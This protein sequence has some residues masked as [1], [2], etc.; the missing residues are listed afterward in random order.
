ML[1][2]LIYI[3]KNTPLEELPHKYPLLV[4]GFLLSIL[5][6]IVM[7]I[8]SPFGAGITYAGVMLI[9]HDVFSGGRQY[10]YPNYKMAAIK[11]INYNEDSIWFKLDPTMKTLTILDE[12]FEIFE[13]IPHN[14][15]NIPDIKSSYTSWL[16]KYPTDFLIDT[17]DCLAYI[18]ISKKYV[19][20][21]VR[22]T[23]KYKQVKENILEHFEFKEPK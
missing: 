17:I 19:H 12:M 23:R 18:I 7:F 5:G 20:V 15:E 11:S 4:A 8:Y 21:I 16:Q 22:N 2:N 1:I 9:I 14:K 10:K 13:S 3:L 6:V